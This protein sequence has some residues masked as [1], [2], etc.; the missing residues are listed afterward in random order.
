M[1]KGVATMNPDFDAAQVKQLADKLAQHGLPPDWTSWF[2][3]LALFVV[4]TAIA[5]AIGAYIGKRS[6][7]SAVKSRLDDIV[8]QTRA[9]T[10]ATAVIHSDLT[11]LD[12]VEKKKWELKQVFYW[13]LLTNLDL[14]NG[15]YM[16]AA[17]SYEIAEKCKATGDTAGY[18]RW[19]GDGNK[20]V[21][22]AKKYRA[23]LNQIVAVAS[24]LTHSK[25]TELLSQHIKESAAAKLEP[26]T[27]T[28]YLSL[29][30]AG[31]KLYINAKDVAIQDLQINIH[32]M[33]TPKEN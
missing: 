29:A 1:Q 25:L 15:A 22:Q 10:R 33:T 3:L 32:E 18:G 17:G 21:D 26:S 23:E 4:L 7:I 30:N 31:I 20:H 2:L 5:A 16:S 19:L 8:N 11:R 9:I 28:F 13:D 24:I 6:E 14:M 27:P 12:W